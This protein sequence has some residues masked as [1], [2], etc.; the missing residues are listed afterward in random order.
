MWELPPHR[1]ARRQEGHRGEHQW[2]KGEVALWHVV[3]SMTLAAGNASPSRRL[4]HVRMDPAVLRLA[5]GPR[6]LFDHN[7]VRKHHRLEP[8]AR[9]L[10]C[11][12]EKHRRQLGS[13]FL[14]HATAPPHSLAADATLV[15]LPDDEHLC[16]EE[17]LVPMTATR[18]GFQ[19][20]WCIFFHHVSK[21]ARVASMGLWCTT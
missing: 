7:H 15:I 17:A 1:G 13:C 9:G 3:E 8:R 14:R 10:A 18:I 4:D 5:M 21:K 6:E 12:K 19:G 16:A 2:P 20:V 11:D